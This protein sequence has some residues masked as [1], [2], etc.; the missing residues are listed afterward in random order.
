M[1]FHKKGE[2]G[3]IKL[4]AK[5]ASFGKLRRGQRELGFS[6]RGHVPL[7]FMT[8]TEK[9]CGGSKEV[10]EDSYNTLMQGCKWGAGIKA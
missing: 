1:G 9:F 5:L 3:R 4:T 6:G 7:P 10:P 8:C 2:L